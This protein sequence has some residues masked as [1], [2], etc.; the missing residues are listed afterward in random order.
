M[1]IDKDYCLKFNGCPMFW[2]T[3]DE[4]VA[5]MSKEYPTDRLQRWCQ[6]WTPEQNKALAE[7][8]MITDALR[9]KVHSAP[10]YS[11]DGDVVYYD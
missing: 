6:I 3:Y 9:T 7:D 10:S 2:G 5:Y 11:N 8:K 1:D 4:C